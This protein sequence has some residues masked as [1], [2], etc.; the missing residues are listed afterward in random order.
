M[1]KSLKKL[2]DEDVLEE[3]LK[4][5]DDIYYDVV[6]EDIVELLAEYLRRVRMIFETDY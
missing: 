3:P 1:K 4:E 2:Y 6:D 5:L